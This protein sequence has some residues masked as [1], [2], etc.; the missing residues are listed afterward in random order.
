LVDDIQ[1]VSGKEGTQTE[2][3]HTVQRAL[4]RAKTDR[5]QQRSS[6]A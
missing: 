3:F 4:R 5:D 1:F 2:F 6:P